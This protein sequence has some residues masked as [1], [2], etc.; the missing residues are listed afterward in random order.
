[1]KK[2][3]WF[4][5]LIWWMTA[6]GIVAFGQAPQTQNAPIYSVNSKFVQGWSP[7]YSYDQTSSGLTFKMLG[8]VNYLCGSRV[9]YSGASLT[10]AANSTNYIYLNTSASC[11]PASNTT[12]FTLTTQVPLYIVVTGSSTVTSISDERTIL[13]VLP[14]SSSVNWGSIGGTLSDQSDLNT[15][16]LARLLLSG[17]VLTGPLGTNVEYS[18]GTCTTAATIN[19]ANGNRQKLTLT[20]AD[21][22]VLTFTQPGSGTISV[23]LKIIQSSSGSFNGT[24]SG[25]KWPG[26]T[27]PTI[28]ATSGA[29]DFVS[30]YLDG[31][32]AYCIASQ[33]FQ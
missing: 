25:G 5:T 3:F 9:L 22:C 15:A 11:M 27:V 21:A 28:T 12:G 16:L 23:T 26:G 18:N 6:L 32:N 14:S 7:S 20:N 10:L 30:C 2:L 8:G 33:N 29:V 17:G 19:P 1:M 13:F 4:V 31:T 24:I